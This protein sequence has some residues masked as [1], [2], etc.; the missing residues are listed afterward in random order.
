MGMAEGWHASLQEVAWLE[1][2]KS[3]R[4]FKKK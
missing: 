1:K 4:L 3:G 2:T